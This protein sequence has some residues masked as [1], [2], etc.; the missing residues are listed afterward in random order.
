MSASPRWL[1]LLAG[2][3]LT[4]CSGSEPNPGRTASQTGDTAPTGNF[5]GRFYERSFV[6]TTLTGDSAFLVPWLMS[7]RTRPGAVEREA[8]GFLARS[9]TWE[10]F[11]SERWES[12]PS[13]APWRILPHGSLRIIV[14]QGDAI[15]G[16]LFEEGSRELELEMDDALQEWTGP[17]GET[18]QLQKGAAYLSDRR[19]DGLVLD[20]VRGRGADEPEPGDWAFLTSGDSLQVVL[21]SP[22]LAAPGTVGAYRG[23]ARLDFRN[24]QWPSV[25]VDWTEVRAFQPARRDVPVAWTVSSDDDDVSGVLGVKTTQIHAGDGPGPVLPVDALFEVAGTLEIQG[26]AYPVRGLF[27]HSRS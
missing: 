7:M 26:R 19:V 6:F 5:R 4:A 25:T 14:G 27:R 13:R 23:W 21:E 2:I 15:D 24:L 9:G 20:V 1:V 3:W 12:P 22:E 18:F 8:H 10:E 11:Y 16:I 17:R